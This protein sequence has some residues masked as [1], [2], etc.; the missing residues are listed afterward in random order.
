MARNGHRYVVVVKLGGDGTDGAEVIPDVRDI[1]V[2]RVTESFGI[3]DTIHNHQ[4][5]VL[6]LAGGHW[7]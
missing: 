6:R 5:N 4:K 2:E 7:P 3:A 1:P